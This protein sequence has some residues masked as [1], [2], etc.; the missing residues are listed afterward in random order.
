[1][2]NVGSYRS[3]A[4]RFPFESPIH[5]AMACQGYCYGVEC[6]DPSFSEGWYSLGE[7]QVERC[8]LW[9]CLRCRASHET[10]CSLLCSKSGEHLVVSFHLNSFLLE[11]LPPPAVDRHCGRWLRVTEIVMRWSSKCS[12]QRHTTASAV[13]FGKVV[14]DFLVTFPWHCPVNIR[15]MMTSSGIFRR[16]KQPVNPTETKPLGTLLFL[17]QTIC[18]SQHCIAAL[19]VSVH[20][21]IFWMCPKSVVF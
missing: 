1:M 5:G 13:I 6:S 15:R 2:C 8:R 9:L 17:V 19:P 18:N 20:V 12:R 16:F 10:C 3:S 21:C 11:C 4:P 14:D 7:V